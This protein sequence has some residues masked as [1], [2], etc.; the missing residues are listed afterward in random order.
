MKKKSLITLILPLLFTIGLIQPGFACTMFKLTLLGKTMV[1]NNEDYWIP[2]TRIWFEQ[3]KNGEC[4]AAYVGYDNFFPQG[5][6]N[7]AGLVFD[8]FSEDYKAIR[9]TVGKKIGKNAC[10]TCLR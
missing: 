2:N 10:L 7:Q 6:M 4:G 9:D 8:G 5:G 1:G 3:G